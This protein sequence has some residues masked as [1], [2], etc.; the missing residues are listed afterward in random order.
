MR[1]QVYNAQDAERKSQ[2][3]DLESSTAIANEKNKTKQFE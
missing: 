1:N 3:I 2:I